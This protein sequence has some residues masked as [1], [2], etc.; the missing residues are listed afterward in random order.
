MTNLSRPHPGVILSEKLARMGICTMELVERAGISEKTINAVLDGKCSVTPELAVQFERATQI[1][2]H[3]WLKSQ[4]NYDYYMERKDFIPMATLDPN[5]RYT[6]ADCLSWPEGFRCEIINGVARELP[7][8]YEAHARVSGNLLYML[9]S[10]IKTNSCKYKVYGGIFDVRLPKNGEL[11][12]DKIDTVVQ[13]DLCII[14]DP[15]KLDEYGCCGV[16]DM[17][18]EILSPATIKNDCIRKFLLYEEHGV[19]EYWMVHPNDKAITVFLLQKNGKYEGFLYEF[20]GKAPVHV[21][22]NHLLDL[23]DIFQ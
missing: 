8:V 10:Y 21:L 13:P 9:Y 18:I 3:F 15:S 2:V 6:Y 1:S 22:D 17:I 7:P 5:K 14:C 23:E 12:Y 19:R 20:K 4:K 11:A 16:P